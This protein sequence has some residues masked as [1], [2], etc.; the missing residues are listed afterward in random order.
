MPDTHI[1]LMNPNGGSTCIDTLPTY[2]RESCAKNNGRLVSVHW[3]SG[4]FTAVAIIELDS[5]LVPVFSLETQ[6]ELGETVILP[7]LDEE[8]ARKAHSHWHHGPH[9]AY[10]GHG[11]PTPPPLP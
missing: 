6:T 1:V 10:G 9:T 11:G 3:T 4:P 5:T 2:F 7:A 8:Q